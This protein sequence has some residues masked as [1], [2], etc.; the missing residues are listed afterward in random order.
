MLVPLVRCRGRSMMPDRWSSEKC[1]GSTQE[2][3]PV[4]ERGQ[5]V[6]QGFPWFFRE[7]NHFHVLPPFGINNLK[8]R[9]KMEINSSSAFGTSLSRAISPPSTLL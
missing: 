1:R 2:V 3:T 5:D 9:L 4:P 8:S 7:R 6:K